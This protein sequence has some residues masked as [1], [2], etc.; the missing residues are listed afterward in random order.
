LNGGEGIYRQCARRDGI[1]LRGMIA[2]VL[3]APHL[4]MSH[5][6]KILNTPFLA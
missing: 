2:V 3:A 1:S 4:E 5:D 6:I